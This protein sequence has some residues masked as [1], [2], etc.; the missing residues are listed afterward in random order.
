M[1]A[2]QHR[3]LRLADLVARLVFGVVLLLL[4]P[5]KMYAQSGAGSIQG[6][7]QD[8]TGA[9]IPGAVIHLV[10]DKTGVSGDT[11]ANGAGFYSLPSLFAGSYTLTIDAPGMKNYKTS[12]TLDVG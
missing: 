4:P 2:N 3:L 6:T 10:N 8:S 12:I 11:K 5:S 7:I 1:Q 9:I